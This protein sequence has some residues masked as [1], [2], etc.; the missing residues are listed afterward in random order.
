MWHTSIRPDCA[1]LSR[2]CNDE[3]L[4]ECKACLTCF[5]TSFCTALPAMASSNDCVT[6]ATVDDCS[7]CL[8]RL[9]RPDR[10]IF[11]TTCKHQFHFQCLAKNIQAKNNECPLCRTRLDSLTDILNNTQSNISQRHSVQSIKQAQASSPTPASSRRVW[12]T[13]TRSL[14]NAF[15]YISRSLP[16]STSAATSSGQNSTSDVS[17]RCPT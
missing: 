12:S 2:L 1:T 7:I 3:T 10:D 4:S 11:T 16:R 13:L 14:S 17:I 15:G 6:S 8:T 9:V 5:L